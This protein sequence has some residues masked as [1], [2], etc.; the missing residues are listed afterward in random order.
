MFN[1]SQADWDTLFYF[2]YLERVG[3]DKV[4]GNNSD[5]VVAAGEVVRGAGV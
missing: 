4:K 2:G 5:R 3:R 1:E